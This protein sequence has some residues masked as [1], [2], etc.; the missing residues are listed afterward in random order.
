MFKKILLTFLLANFLFL[1]VFSKPVQAQ[2]PQA[3]STWYQQTF[4]EW[5]DKVYDAQNQDEIFGERY[6]AAQVEWVLFGTF[7]FIIN[8]VGSR[9]L[10]WCVIHLWQTGI[11]GS[12]GSFFQNL[13]TTCPEA[14]TDL[15]ALFLWAGAGVGV[16]GADTKPLPFAS[17]IPVEKP[18][19]PPSNYNLFPSRG[20]SFVGYLKNVGS[21]LKII[22]ETQ[23]QGFGANRALRGIDNLWRFVRDITYFVLIIVIIVLAFMIM[24]RVK[25][26]PQTVVTLQ[27]AIPKV[28]ITLILVTFSYAIA[29]FMV[30]LMYVVL[31][32]IAA[33]FT[34][35]DGISNQTWAEMF[36]AFTVNNTLGVLFIYVVL[37][38]VGVI[39]SFIAYFGAL[40]G[41]GGAWAGGIFGAFLAILA[42]IVLLIVMVVLSLR[43][44]WMMI[45][46]YVEILLLTA[47]SPIMIVGGAVG[48]LGFGAWARQMAARLA[49]YPV[50]AILLVFTFY[51]LATAFGGSVGGSDWIL[52]RIPFHP[53]QESLISASTSWDPP[54]TIGSGAIELLFLFV[55]VV[56][57]TLI[58]RAAEIVRGAFSG[59]PFAMGTAIGDALGPAR[60]AGRQAEG[61]T[62]GRL[63]ERWGIGGG[64]NWAQQTVSRAAVRRG[65]ARV[66]DESTGAIRRT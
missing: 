5:Y 13:V 58:P 23:A 50:V 7:S 19:P 11:S 39:Y 29:G 55:S 62:M 2:S 59:R 40:A 63:A 53:R 1:S 47:F 24:F 6:T 25:L 3:I 22:P 27:S 4:F 31:G 15:N 21:K 38:F 14:V 12:I 44:V 66:T 42:A 54:L 60:W 18:P 17:T 45:R 20:L 52:A 51:F 10:N 48:V 46:N 26:S 64:T 35:P 61:Q 56:T 43:I 65:H 33:L 30:D 41:V 36:Q 37:F 49:V 32:L 8:R 34:S 16:F 57:L 9:H 28:I